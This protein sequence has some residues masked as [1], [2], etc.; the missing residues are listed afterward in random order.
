MRPSPIFGERPCLIEFS[1]S[2]WSS[3]LGSTTSSVAGSIAFSIDSFGPNRTAS[4]SRYSSIASSSSRS[5]TKC[6]W[7]R[8]RRRS[9]P[10][11]FT[12]SMRA[13]SGCDRISDEIEVSV[14]NRKCGLIWLSS[15]ST[16]AVM[17][18]FSCSCS[19]CSMRAAVP[20]LDRD[21]DAQTPWRTRR[22]RGATSRKA[23]GRRG[24]APIDGRAPGAGAR[25]R[26]AP[27][28]AARPS[29]FA[30]CARGARRIDGDR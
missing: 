26:S 30:A 24:A 23:C 4:M 10:D 16:R 13:V 22:A 1:T 9:S 17:S 28:A 3:M 6:S 8:S 29:R 12:I 2:G 25:A 14:L 11:S 27:R 7:L 19:R 15:A 5:V 21:R 20:D 18:S